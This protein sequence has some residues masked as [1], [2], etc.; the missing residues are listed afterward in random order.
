MLKT[1]SPDDDARL[2]MNLSFAWSRQIF[3]CVSELSFVGS[4]NCLRCPF[5]M[6]P[7]RCVS[8]FRRSDEF[9]KND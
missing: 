1:R 2:I 5:T 6:F 8:T 7:H 9:W 3:A 4:N